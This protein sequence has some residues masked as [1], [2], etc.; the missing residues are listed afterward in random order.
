[1]GSCFISSLLC[2]HVYSV[3][4]EVELFRASLNDAFL[5]A[6]WR[7][8]WSGS[9]IAKKKREISYIHFYIVAFGT[10]IYLQCFVFGLLS[11]LAYPSRKIRR[12]F[13]E[14]RSS[15][16]VRR[17]Y[18]AVNSKSPFYI[19]CQLPDWYLPAFLTGLWSSP[20]Q[21]PWKSFLIPLCF[22]LFILICGVSE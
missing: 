5:T 13:S 11:G 22:Y 14:P 6:L 1:M 21:Q 4:K 18:T 12:I 10:S 20:R 17:V 2:R 7:L 3:Y 16:Q 19:Q 9:L 8:M 15:L